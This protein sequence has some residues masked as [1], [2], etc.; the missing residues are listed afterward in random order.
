MRFVE[1]R[2][3]KNDTFYPIDKMESL[4]NNWLFLYFKNTDNAH[5]SL[6]ISN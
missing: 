4:Q 3:K 2:Q 5:K 6:T 1:Q